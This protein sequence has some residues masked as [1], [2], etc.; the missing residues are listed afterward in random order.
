M[1]G[2]ASSCASSSMS[3]SKPRGEGAA[4]PLEEERVWRPTMEAWRE[5]R[6]EADSRRR[7]SLDRE[8]EGGEAGGEGG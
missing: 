5:G 4:V 6:E 1:C 2:E 7:T 8:A 3:E